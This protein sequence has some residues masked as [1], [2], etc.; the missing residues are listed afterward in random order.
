M[1]TIFSRVKGTVN[2]IQEWL[3]KT[4]EA[5]FSAHLVTMKQHRWHMAIR[6]SNLLYVPLAASVPPYDAMCRAGHA[7]HIYEIHRKSV[8]CY[9]IDN[10]A[11]NANVLLHNCSSTECALSISTCLM[12]LCNGSQYVM[13]YCVHVY[14]WADD[15]KSW[16]AFQSRRWGEWAVA[17]AE[18]SAQRSVLTLGLSL[19]HGVLQYDSSHASSHYALH[20]RTS[21]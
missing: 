21:T 19:A 11:K 13:S 20:L 14:S 5:S 18:L 4:P 1:L 8:M 17:L 16:L 15:F 2:W 12:W 7:M 6:C 9:A 3:N 10:I